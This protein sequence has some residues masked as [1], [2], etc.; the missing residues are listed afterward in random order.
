MSYNNTPWKE[1]NLFVDSSTFLP[2]RGLSMGQRL[3]KRPL[4]LQ[5]TG[6]HIVVLT[7]PTALKVSGITPWVHH[8]RVKK[9][10][11]PDEEINQWR[12]QPDHKKPL[13]L[14]V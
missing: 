4:K 1:P 8:S 11:H 10:R 13:H 6:P 7:T 14:H 2:G 12:A 9:T 5:W 3:E